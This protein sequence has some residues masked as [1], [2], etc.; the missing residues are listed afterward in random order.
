[1]FKNNI[2]FQ[3]C[4]QST[5]LRPLTQIHPFLRQLL[6]HRDPLLRLTGLQIASKMAERRLGAEIL[7]PVTGVNVD[8]SD[9]DGDNLDGDNLDGVDLC[10]FDIDGF[11][12][13]RLNNN[14]WVTC[15]KLF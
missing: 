10:G 2:I 9:L 4:H 8:G 11:N 5:D 14:H 12:H 6:R 3:V 7:V 15:C 13:H 1:M